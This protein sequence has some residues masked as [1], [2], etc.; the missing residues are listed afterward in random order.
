MKQLLKGDIIYIDLGNKGRTSVQSGLRPCIVIG[1]YPTSPVATVAPLTSKMEKAKIPVHVE[2][3]PD[4]VMG[5]LEKKSIILVEQLT[6]ID[7]RKIISKIGHVPEESEVMKLVDKA[8]TRQLD[9]KKT[10]N[11]SCS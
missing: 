5:Y 3:C 6:T 11:E 7:R 2:I 9:I 1:I 4:D 10:V 8:V